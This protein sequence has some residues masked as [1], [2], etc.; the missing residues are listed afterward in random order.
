[1]RRSIV[2]PALVAPLAMNRV[3]GG[4]ALDPSE[5][6]TVHNRP[7]SGARPIEYLEADRPYRNLG[8]AAI[9]PS[10]VAQGRN[11]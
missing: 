8:K 4:R 7:E 2:M 6:P 11:A 9:G 5:T 10:I 1:M 3:G